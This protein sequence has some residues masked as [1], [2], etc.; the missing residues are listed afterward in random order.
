MIGSASSIAFERA[1]LAAAFAT[2][3]EAIIA[4]A[5]ASEIIF[6]D[7]GV[8]VSIN[9]LAGPAT[10]G[11]AAATLTAGVAVGLQAAALAA[12]AVAYTY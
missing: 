9:A 1:A 3:S 7:W 6:L 10:T 4:L 5:M 2:G 11:A 8:K 12:A